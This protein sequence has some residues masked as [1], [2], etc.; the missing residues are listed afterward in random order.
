VMPM[1]APPPAPAAAAVPAALAE[2][3][4]GAPGEAPAADGKTVSA[5]MVGTFYRR[6]KP[7]EPPFVEE[8]TVVK[9]GDPL[10][11]IEVMKLYTTIEAPADGRVV[12][13]AAEDAALVEFDQ[14]LIVLEPI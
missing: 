10:C 9:A 14:P 5:P 7:E 12:S 11:L 4:P 6:S 1:Q 2:M 3:S 13:I 8:G